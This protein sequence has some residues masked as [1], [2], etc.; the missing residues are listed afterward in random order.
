MVLLHDR[1]GEA[2]SKKSGSYDKGK[3]ARVIR[4]NLSLDVKEMKQ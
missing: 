4:R 2:L 1:G 3:R